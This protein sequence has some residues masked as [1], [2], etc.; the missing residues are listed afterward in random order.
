MPSQPSIEAL[1]GQTRSKPTTSGIVHDPLRDERVVPV[2]RR[3]D[4]SLRKEIKIRPGFT[5]AEDQ[6]KFRSARQ[7]DMDERERS[8]IVPG[9]SRPAPVGSAPV[10][11]HKTSRR[12]PKKKEAVPAAEPDIPDDWDAEEDSPA[13]VA[14]EANAAPSAPLNVASQDIDP[15]SLSPEERE[16]RAR[17][18]AK[19]LR[20]ARQLADK[21]KE[22]TLLPEQK[23]KVDSIDELTRLLDALSASDT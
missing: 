8:N 9:I 19:K 21:A 13:P 4:G 17:Q 1:L 16:R 23:A 22:T 5:P 12:R 18:I 3:P 15:S 6:S 2:S 14:S 11:E 20:Q 10:S 7:L